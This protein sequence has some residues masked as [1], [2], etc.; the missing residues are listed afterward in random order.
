M[1]MFSH[2]AKKAKY[3]E[4][5]HVLFPKELKDRLSKAADAFQVSEGQIIRESV[6]ERLSR[7]ENGHANDG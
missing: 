6:L 3:T 2:M 5:V 7:S 4:H 1:C